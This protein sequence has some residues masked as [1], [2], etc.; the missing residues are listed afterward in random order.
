VRVRRIVILEAELFPVF[1]A[2][3][4]EQFIDFHSV[5]LS[6]FP[7]CRVSKIRYPTWK[8]F[9][10]TTVSGRPT[11]L[12]RQFCLA[13]KGLRVGTPQLISESK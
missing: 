11:A 7:S 13:N 2:V 5:T 1:D 4:L 6:D 12:E 9:A 3:A 8:R 10:R